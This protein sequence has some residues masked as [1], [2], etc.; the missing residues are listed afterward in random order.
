VG[1]ICWATAFVLI[2]YLAGSQ[3]QRVEKYANYVGVGLLAVVVG[4]VLVRR[5]HERQSTAAGPADER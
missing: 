5:R 4:V 3:Y 2:G 1:G